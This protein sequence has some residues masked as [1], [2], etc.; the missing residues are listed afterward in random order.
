MAETAALARAIARLREDAKE[1]LGKAEKLE[2]RLDAIEGERDE[3]RGER[4]PKDRKK[5]RDGKER[6]S[7]AEADEDED[8]LEVDPEDDRD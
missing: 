1:L 4:R 8:E 5:D 2:E 7:R 6:K 3:R